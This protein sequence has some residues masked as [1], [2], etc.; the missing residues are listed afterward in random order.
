MTP[1]Q[2]IAVHARYDIQTKMNF[3]ME[4]I[5][6]IEEMVKSLP[7]LHAD[8]SGLRELNAALP[9]FDPEYEEGEV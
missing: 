7:Q 1:A 4:E 2:R 5:A 6:Q 8:V 9:S 3:L